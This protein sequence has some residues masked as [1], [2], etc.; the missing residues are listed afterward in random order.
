MAVGSFSA[1][2]SGLN[3]NAH[4]PQRHRQQPGEHQ[5]RRLQGQLGDVHGPGQ[6]DVGGPSTNPM[7]IGLGVVT[8]SISPI[9]SQGAIENTREAT[10]VA[11]Q[12]AGFFVVKGPRRPRPTRAPAT[13]P[14]TTRASWSRR[15]A[16]AVQGFTAIDP[17]TGQDRHDRRADRHRRAAG[18]AARAASRRRSFGDQ[19][20]PRCRRATV[21]DDVRD[22]RRADLRRARHA[23]HRH[24]D[25]HE[26]AAAGAWNYAIDGAGAEVDR[27][28]AGAP[29]SVTSGAVQFDAT[30]KLS[31]FTTR[32]RQRAAARRPLTSPSRRRP[33]PT[34]RRPS[35]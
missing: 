6:P 35:R 14:S 26:A 4:V 21:G 11:I 5:H 7:Q 8:G 18:R 24:D 2:L 16:S 1:G 32:R 28:H 13:S 10:N 3:A 9:F 29:F 25:L 31:S 34:A 22:R 33:G 12:G 27:R 30:G 15:T 23:A 19:H 17:V 20:Q